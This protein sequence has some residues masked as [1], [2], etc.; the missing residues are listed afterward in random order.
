MSIPYYNERPPDK[1]RVS[2]KQ[3]AEMYYLL[4]ETDQKILLLLR[5]CRYAISEQI[6]D[7]LFPEGSSTKARSR[8]ANRR[9]KKLRELSLIEA[10]GRTIGGPRHGSSHNVWYLSELGH[11][12]LNLDET[13][14]VRKRLTAPSMLFI[15]HTLAI[16]EAY[17]QIVRTAREHPE[18]ILSE[19]QWEPECW[20]N[21]AKN[22]SFSLRPDMF[23]VTHSE[24]YEDRWF[25]ELDLSTE[26]IGTVISK[27]GR[28]LEYYRTEHEQKKHGVFPR[29]L[30]IVPDA[31]R[32]NQLKKAISDNYAGQPELFS[33]VLPDELPGMLLQQIPTTDKEGK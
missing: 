32:K 27:C 25:I 9:L 30:W 17:V 26:D 3:L 14:A 18:L 5:D 28:Y 31:V 11:R 24:Q 4:P 29:V 33:I 12:M 1:H 19:V 7:L 8:A 16:T 22:N 23:I 20:R 2:K 10:F 15:R 6:R 13:N 21:P